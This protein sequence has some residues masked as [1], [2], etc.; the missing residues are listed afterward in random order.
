V[1]RGRPGSKHNLLV[2]QTGIP[3]AFALTGSNRNDITQLIPLVEAVPAVR[4]VVGRP[5]RRPDSVIAD[6]G[7]DHDR[8]RRLLRRRG[9]KPMIARRQTE[10]GSGLGRYRWVVERTC[11]TS[12]GCSCATSAGRTCTARCSPAPAA[13]SASVGS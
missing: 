2:D 13:S 7:Y 4:G 8:Y 12:S 1:D 3:L 5:R 6:R 10:H 9:I 11:T